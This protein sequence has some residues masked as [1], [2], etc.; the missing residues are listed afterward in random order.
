M[1]ILCAYPIIGIWVFKMA[2]WHD[3]HVYVSTEYLHTHTHI[4]TSKPVRD[5]KRSSEKNRDIDDD[6]DSSK[7][8]IFTPASQSASHGFCTVNKADARLI[9]E[10]R[11]KPHDD[12]TAAGCRDTMTSCLAVGASNVSAV[13]PDHHHHHHHHHLVV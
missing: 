8:T 3:I 12:A 5:S 10:Q 4:Q 7:F 1:V 6:D 2:L 9:P 11:R 13:L